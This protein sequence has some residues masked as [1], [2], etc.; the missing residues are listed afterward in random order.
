[1]T[2]GPRRGQGNCCLER[3]TITTRYRINE[4]SEVARLHGHV[5]RT[6]RHRSKRVSTT[7]NGGVGI[8]RA[9]SG[10]TE[11]RCCDLVVLETR[12][13]IKTGF[14]LFD[15]IVARPTFTAFFESEEKIRLVKSTMPLMQVRQH[16]I[17]QVGES[18]AGLDPNPTFENQLVTV[19]SEG[20]GLGCC[21]DDD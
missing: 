15:K 14:L 9:R 16:V 19:L 4:G 6:P 18:T 20:F 2:R 17:H 12:C 8:D 5:R 1:M 7:S 10:R 21:S 3:R 11:F 13:P